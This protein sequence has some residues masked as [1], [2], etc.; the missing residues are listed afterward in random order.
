MSSFQ[1]QKPIDHLTSDDVTA[2]LETMPDTV[3][4]RRNRTLLHLL[5]KSGLRISEALDLRPVDVETR[6]GKTTVNVRRGKGNKQRQ[7]FVF[8]GAADDLFAW[9]DERAAL[10]ATE[11]EP[12]FCAVHADAV[13]RPVDRRAI[14][15]MVKRAAL[16]AGIQGKR[17][18][19]HSFRHAHAKELF[20]RG[21]RLD[22]IKS[23]LGHSSLLAT[24]AYLESIGC[25]ESIDRLAAVEW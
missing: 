10:G 6:D 13:G 20:H 7:A 3:S 17:V 4:G 8:N 14:G 21:V 12:I 22:D 19:P 18:H 9:L 11:T 25:S 23:Q 2:M 24:Q 16:S 1:R 5:W 15:P